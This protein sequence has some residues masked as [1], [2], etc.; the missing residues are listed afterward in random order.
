LIERSRGPGATILPATNEPR[1]ARGFL[2]PAIYR[3]LGLIGVVASE[4]G[5]ISRPTTQVLSKVFMGLMPIGI[6]SALL[7]AGRFDIEARRRVITISRET[8]PVA[9]WLATA[10]LVVLGLVLLA[11]FAI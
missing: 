6:A 1:L 8:S 7:I 3:A 5:F 2:L 4:L 9:F 11:A 10:G